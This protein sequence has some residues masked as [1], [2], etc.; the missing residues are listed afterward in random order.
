MTTTPLILASVG[1]TFAALP[2]LGIAPGYAARRVAA[3][4]AAAELPE[5]QPVVVLLDAALAANASAVA[6]LSDRVAFLG[7]GAAGA[8]EPAPAL[9]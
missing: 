1:R 7:V 8:V 4:P 5:D 9:P 2:S 3:L 6:A